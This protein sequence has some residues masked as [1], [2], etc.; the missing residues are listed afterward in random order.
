MLPDRSVFARGIHR[1][2]SA[3]RPTWRSFHYENVLGT[4]FE[5]RVLA[6]CEASARRAEATVLGEIDRLETI[7]SGYSPESELM[8][9]QATSGRDIAI[10]PELAE[11]L[12]AAELWRVRTNDA[13]NPAAQ[14]IVDALRA[15]RSLVP[16]TPRATDLVREVRRPLWCV[17]L[18]RGTA[19]RL[20]TLPTTLDGLAKGYIVARAAARAG[21][22]PG[23]SAIML[24]IGG[25][26]QHVGASAIVAGITDPL[27]PADNVPPIARVRIQG[28]GLATSGGYRRGFEAN[29]RRHSHIVDPR[30]GASVRRVVGASVIASDCMIA[31]ALST[32]LSVLTPDEGITLADSLPGVGCLLVEAGGRVRASALWR[33]RTADL[34]PATGAAPSQPFADIQDYS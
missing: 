2:V 9:W 28:G 5:L 31:D 22:T 14:A 23:V 20:T 24:N 27:D 8:R 11:V 26:I 30:S 6:D 21:E 13:F 17:D 29:G 4:S 19:R 15:P 34:R 7:L 18:P 25:D 16:G 1:F 33:A 12:D 32:A 3:S 10:S